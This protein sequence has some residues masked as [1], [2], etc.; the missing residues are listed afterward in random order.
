VSKNN[1]GG[2][3]YPWLEGFFTDGDIK[4]LADVYVSYV[5]TY[6]TGYTVDVIVGIDGK[7]ILID[8][9]ISYDSNRDH[10]LIYGNY[11]SPID[12]TDTETDCLL[13]IQSSSSSNVMAMFRDKAGSTTFNP[14][15]SDLYNMRRTSVVANTSMVSCS[16]P[17]RVPYTGL[18]LSWDNIVQSQPNSV[19]NDR[20]FGYK[21][22]TN[23]NIVRLLTADS[24]IQNKSIYDDNGTDYFVI[25]KYYNGSMSKDQFS[26]AVPWYSGNPT[27]NN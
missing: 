25:A 16:N 20:G 17:N 22:I 15:S 14:G 21:G 13:A 26:I 10:C 27:I 23:P 8:R 11:I 7:N 1:F 6:S 24:V 4:P 19:L 18:S 9:R 12:N 2:Y 5:D 3:N